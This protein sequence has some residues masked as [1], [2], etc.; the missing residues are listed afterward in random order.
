MLPLRKRQKRVLD[1][2][3][4]LS[5]KYGFKMDLVNGTLLEIVAP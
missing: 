1:H 3:V 2:I 4:H 5:T